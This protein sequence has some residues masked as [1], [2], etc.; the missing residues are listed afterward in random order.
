[1]KE[2]DYIKLQASLADKGHV[3]VH[4]GGYYQAYGPGAYAL[5]RALNY[6]VIR[7]RRPWG[8]VLTCGFPDIVLS[9]VCL[10]LRKTRAD[11]E[12]LSDNTF[13]VYGLDGTPDD[14]L[15][16]DAVEEAGT[17]VTD[18]PTVCVAVDWL[19]DAVMG[20]D[21]FESSVKDA[22]HFINMLQRRLNQAT[23][24]IR[25]QPQ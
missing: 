2:Q 4:I 20:Y 11:M 24:C 9:R 7:R 25:Y 8:E 12:L 19:A 1:M 6:R 21:L 16:W 5:S 23:T 13:L 18:E 22:L 10:R 15:V 17:T 14:V 3:L